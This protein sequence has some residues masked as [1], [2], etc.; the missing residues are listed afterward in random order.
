MEKGGRIRVGWRRV[1]WSWVWMEQGWM[2]EGL[3]DKDWKEVG[4]DEWRS[5]DG[6]WRVRW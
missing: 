2:E 4:L 6:W 3:M 1:K 5:L